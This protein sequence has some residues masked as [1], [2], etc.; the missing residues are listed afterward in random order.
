MSAQRL[1]AALILGPD[2]VHADACLVVEGGIVRGVEPAGHPD[3]LDLGDVALVP[4]LVNAHSHAFQRILRGRTESLDPARPEEDFWT[5]RDLMYRAALALDGD[6]VEVVARMAFAEMAR[7]GITTVG[8]FHYLHH[9]PDG[10]D[11]LA[12]RVVQAARDVGLRIALLRVAYHRAGAGRPARPDQRRFVEPDVATFLARADALR[13]RW[14]D[15]ALVSVGLAPHSIRAA[16]GPWIAAIAAHARSENFPLHLHACEQRAE[17][18][19][20]RAEY[21]VEP[22][23]ALDRLGALG[24]GTTLVHATH[25]E[26]DALARIADRG[27]TVCACPTTEANLGDGFLPASALRAAGVPIALGTDS[28]A[29]VDLFQEARRVDE[30]ERLLRERRVPFARHG[31]PGPAGRIEVADQLWPMATTHGGRALGLPVGALAPG[32]PPTSSRWI[33]PSLP[34]PAPIPRLRGALV[35]AATPRAVRDVYVA[36]RPICVA[37]RHPDEARIVADYRALVATF[38]A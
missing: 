16:P 8:E 19:E 27:V 21:G 20:A 32:A 22:V 7:A 9:G 4:G 29:T 2:A 34:S 38:S 12:D 25:L 1:R 31:L 13:A 11:T 28:Q 37:G 14:R 23:A 10:A 15:D 26:D 18:S 6:G 33:W 17:L 30:H 3:A 5:W 35:F 36:G 24:P